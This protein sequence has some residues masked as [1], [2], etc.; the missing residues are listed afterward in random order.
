MRKRKRTLFQVKTRG[1]WAVEDEGYR[2]GYGDGIRRR[3]RRK[4]GWF[5][6]LLDD[7][8]TSRRLRK[9]RWEAYNRGYDDGW[10]QAGANQRVIIVDKDGEG[11][12]AV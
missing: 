6:G 5:W 10:E 3:V 2:D 9:A 4:P 11:T 7:P 1:E 8:L 12:G